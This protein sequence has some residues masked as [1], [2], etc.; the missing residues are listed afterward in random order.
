MTNP[1]GRSFLSYRRSR[2]HEAELLISAQHDVGVP[3]WQDVCDLENAPLEDELV[4]ALRDSNTA[5]AVL[6]VTPE[7]GT[8]DVVRRVEVPL[9][10]ERARRGD[11]YF[12]NPVAAGGLDYGAAAALVAPTDILESLERW[13]MSRVDSDPLNAHDAA[14]IAE[15]VLAHRLARVH[16][17]LAPGEPVR[18]RLFTRAQ[19]AFD[20]AAALTIDWSHHFD[21]RV[22]RDDNWRLHCLPALRTVAGCLRKNAPGREILAD[23]LAS[24]PAATALGVAF[25]APGGVRAAWRQQLQGGGTA[26]WSIES[27]REASGFNAHIRGGSVGATDLA[28]LLSVNAAVEGSVATTPSLPAFRAVVDVRAETGHPVTLTS[29][30]ATDVAFLAI[31]S[32]RSARQSH[33]ATGRVHLFM[34]APAGLAFMLGQLL[35]TF[36]E[37]QTYEHVAEQGHYAVSALLRPSD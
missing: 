22:C 33:S 3:T 13:N 5:N 11:G 4:G 34:A 9:I 28:V 30:Q 15:S 8:S 2:L 18:L 21:G 36:G 12:V 37:V 26:V 19:P 27:P 17:T 31:E 23:G 20:A 32:M 7:I 1:N 25:L 24:L 14:A 10:L 35:N 29:G 6:W 16:A